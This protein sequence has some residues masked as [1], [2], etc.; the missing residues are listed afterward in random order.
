MLAAAGLLIVGAGMPLVG[1]AYADSGSDGGSGTGAAIGGYTADT[2]STPVSVQVYE[3]VIPLPVQPGKPQGEL[4]LSFTNVSSSTGPSNVATASSLW[5]GAGLGDGFTTLTQTF[6]LGA[7]DYPV[8]AQASYPGGPPSSTQGAPPVAT[9]ASTAD[10]KSATAAATVADLL[11]AGNAL[12]DAGQISSRS[13]TTVADDK[14]SAATTSLAQDLSLAGGLIDIA[15]VRTAATL[16]STAADSSSTGALAITGLSIAG[17]QFSVDQDGVHAS[18]QGQSLP[19]LPIPG[20]PTQPVDALKAMGITFSGPTVEK[21]IAGTT[22]TYQARALEISID[23]VPLKNALESLTHYQDTYQQLV[24]SLPDQLQ[25]VVNNPQVPSLVELGPR[26]VYDLGLV[27]AKTTASAQYT[28]NFPTLPVPGP[29]VS[30]SLGGTGLPA[31]PGSSMGD[32][33]GVTGPA[34][35]VAP[36]DQGP[37]VAGGAQKASALASPFDGLPAWTVLVALAAAAAIGW[38]LRRLA[39]MAGMLPAGG[40]A[41]RLGAGSGVP[42][43]REG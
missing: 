22:A 24:G 1:A 28:Y 11:P 36:S 17:F 37:V 14:V 42:N 7:A 43:L 40:A 12:V 18:G 33:G 15:T 4:D 39:M 31:L 3:P 6:G 5:P 38:G 32:L 2:S 27:T 9:M 23:T 29:P 26:I 16:T 34:P 30:A 10:E 21:H 13:A 25:Q 20:L 35:S 41:C 8:K 19:K